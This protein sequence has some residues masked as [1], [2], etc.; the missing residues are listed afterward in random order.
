MIQGGR[1]R[2]ATMAWDQCFGMADFLG[3]VVLNSA[4][5]RDK[6]CAFAQNFAKVYAL[7]HKPGTEYRAV[8]N[9]VEFNISNGRKIFKWF[10][11]FP[12]GAVQ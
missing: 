6:F 5:G 12:E 4:K 2:I 8:S 3:I 11:F 7:Q 1:A 10:K 9:A